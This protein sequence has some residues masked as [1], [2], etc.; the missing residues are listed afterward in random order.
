MNSQTKYKM[1]TR[2]TTKLIIDIKEE[3]NQCKDIPRSWLGRLNIVKIL[4]LP[5][6]ICRFSAIPIKVSASYFVDID[7]L[8]LKFISRGKRPSI[9]LTILGEKNKVRGLA[10]PHF[11]TYHKALAIKRVWFC[12][13]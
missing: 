10:L 6:S 13:Y 3:L 8:I 7:K 11:K 12:N 5:N 9:A 4:V 2:K 1:S